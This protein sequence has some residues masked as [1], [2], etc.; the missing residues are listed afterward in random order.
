MTGKFIKLKSIHINV[1]VKFVIREILDL[2]YI[3]F[4]FMISSLSASAQG[5]NY[6]LTGSY[7]NSKSKGIHVYDFNSSN[8][9]SGFIDS[10]S[11]SNP[12]YLAVSPDQK[13]VLAVN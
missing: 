8:G 13:F 6:M 7:T 4:A 2:K 3:L 10:A 11:T 5:H 9:S 12:T 1:S